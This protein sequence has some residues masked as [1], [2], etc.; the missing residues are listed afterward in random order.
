MKT[1]RVVGVVIRNDGLCNK[2]DDEII[3]SALF[4]K[5][6]QL[7][8]V[9]ERKK[10]ILSPNERNALQDEYERTFALTEQFHQVSGRRANTMIIDDS[11]CCPFPDCKG[12]LK[13]GI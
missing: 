11:V 12:G 3:R 8:R 5:V 7:E 1:K 2:T 4:S 13:N 6:G 10:H 9:L